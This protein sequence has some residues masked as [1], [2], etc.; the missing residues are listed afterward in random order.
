MWKWGCVA[1]SGVTAGKGDPDPPPP[2]MQAA[3]GLQSL[4][5]PRAISELR[6]W[7]Q[8]SEHTVRG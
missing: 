5:S 2:G 1:G 6:Q 4:L 3:V 7:I 8:D